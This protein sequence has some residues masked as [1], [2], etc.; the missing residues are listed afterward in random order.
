MALSERHAVLLQHLLP[1]L[2]LLLLVQKLLTQK[3]LLQK[4]KNNFSL[5]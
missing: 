3:R 5:I 4:I 1:A 2:K